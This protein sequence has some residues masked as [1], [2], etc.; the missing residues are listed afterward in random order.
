LLVLAAKSA[1]DLMTKSPKTVR[2]DATL[3]AAASFLIAKEI[4]AAPVVDSSGAIVGVISHTDIVR[5]ESQTGSGSRQEAGFYNDIT[6]RCPPA[7]REI[8]HK[9]KTDVVRVRDVMSPVVIKVA[10]RDPVMTVIAEFLALKIHRL[11]VVDDAEKLVGVISAL[12]VMRH[13]KPQHGR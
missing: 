6:L 13:L 4:S 2:D 7:L 10:A 8:V 11:F 12:D 9:I 5:H 3:R 1:A